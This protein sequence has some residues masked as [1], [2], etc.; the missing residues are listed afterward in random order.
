MAFESG[1]GVTTLH[2]NWLLSFSSPPLAGEIT[3]REAGCEDFFGSLL[4]LTRSWGLRPARQND[5]NGHY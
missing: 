5:G 1:T 3:E 2:E 4:A